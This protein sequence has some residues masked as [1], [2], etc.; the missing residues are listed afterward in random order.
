MREFGSDG[1]VILAEAMNITEDSKK[2]KVVVLSGKSRRN[3]GNLGRSREIETRFVRER[4]ACLVPG[5]GYMIIC[6][7]T[8]LKVLPVVGQQRAVLSIWGSDRLPVLLEQGLLF[9][10]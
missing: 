9:V 4:K 10:S 2:G 3:W 1:G 5:Q 8:K 6:R 7:P